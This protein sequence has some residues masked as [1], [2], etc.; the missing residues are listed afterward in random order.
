VTEAA[1]DEAIAAFGRPRQAAERYLESKPIIAPALR[2]YLFRYASLLFAVH[3][4]FI[5]SA[6]AYGRS[7]VV[8]PF[9]FVPRLG[10]LD[11]V[12]YLPMALL[13]DFGLVALVLYF[14]TRSNREVRLPWPK[15]ALDLDGKTAR[16]TARTAANLVGGVI[17]L[18]IAWLLLSVMRTHGAFFLLRIPSGEFEPLLLP[19]PGLLL[20]LIVIA[21]LAAGALERFVKALT[22]SWQLRCWVSAAVDGFDLLLIAAALGVMSPGMFAVTVPARLHVWLYKSLNWILMV[23]ALIVA[24]DLVANLVRLGRNR[25]AKQKKTLDARR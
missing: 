18:A 17:L 19:L 10:V 2:R 11:A 3:L 22:D 9:L 4:A 7:F 15:L 23:T 21:L 1:F 12:M 24:F 6:V 5:V 16:S 8:F 25:L 13:A 20:S 14:V